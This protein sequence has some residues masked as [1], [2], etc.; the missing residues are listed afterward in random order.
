[1]FNLVLFD[2]VLLFEG[3]DGIDLSSVLLLCQNNLAIGTCTDDLQQVE[4][5]NSQFTVIDL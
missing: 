1:M 2:E 5:I 4:V 3:L